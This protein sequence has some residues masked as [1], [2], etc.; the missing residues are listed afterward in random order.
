MPEPVLHEVEHSE[1]VQAPA[2]EIYRLIAEVGNW[3][4]IFP[5]TIHVEYLE[6]GA[7]VE[8]IRIWA[9]ANGAAKSWSSR[10]ELDPEGLRIRFRQEVSSPPVASMGGTWVVEPIDATS[11]R[12]RLLHDYRAVGDDPEGLAWI[13]AAVDRNSRSELAAL[14]AAAEPGPGGRELLL[15][16]DDTVGIE[17]PAQKVYDFLNEA[18]LW[19]ERL[20]HVA[21]VRLTEDVPGLQLLEMDTLTKDGSSHTTTSVRVCF[22]DTRIVYKQIVVPALMTL[23]TGYWR[24]TERDGRTEATSHHDVVINPRTIAGV[25][26]E[27]AGVGEA[28]AFVRNALGTNSRATLG[29][30]KAYAEGR[31]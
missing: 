21:K 3:P 25:L 29:H 2:A 11:S 15:S 1:R 28:K 30:A 8:R 7:D 10:R 22:P 9:T 19:T 23:H 14:R 12:V 5:P 16:F 27:Q 31:A 17:A 26:G 6:Q 4:R 18:Q 24:L 20:P 13:D